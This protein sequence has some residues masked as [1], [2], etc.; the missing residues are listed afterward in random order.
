MINKFYQDLGLNN[1]ICF[2]HLARK[3]RYDA[4]AIITSSMLIFC[5]LRLELTSIVIEIRPVVHRAMSYGQKSFEL[6]W[7]CH[8]LL[9]GLLSTFP[10]RHVS[11]ACRLIIRT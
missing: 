10:E 1:I 3:M 4:S 11:L 9:S 2:Y 7:Q 5:T 6:V 8:Q